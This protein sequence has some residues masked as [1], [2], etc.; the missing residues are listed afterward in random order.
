MH[1]SVLTAQMR[2]LA[3]K[4]Y[5]NEACGL[6]VSTGRFASLSECKNI[7]PEPRTQFIIDPKDYA[8]AEDA[9]D[10]IGVWHSHVDEPGTPSEADKASC[11]ATELPWFITEIRKTDAGFTTE[12]PVLLEPSGYQAEYLGRPYVFGSFD[13]WSLCVDY[14]HREYNIKL[15]LLMHQRIDTWWDKGLDFFDEAIN[16]E[17]GSQFVKIQ[18]NDY[19][20][21]DLILFSINAN[22]TNHIAI[23]LGDDIILHHVLNRLSRRDTYGVF[24]GKFKTHH[25][26]HRSKC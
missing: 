11:E 17:L 1:D 3:T 14:Y 16:S 2:E 24:W 8:A 6:I 20:P 13:C 26:R 22:V 23:Y 19:L 10:V 4:S 15:P 7:S 5:P 21:G 18:N 12:Q 9:G 25:F